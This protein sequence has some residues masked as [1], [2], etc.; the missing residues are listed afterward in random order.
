MCCRRQDTLGA[1]LV[2]D[3]RVISNSTRESV[4]G[5]GTLLTSSS[6]RFFFSLSLSLPLDFFLLLVRSL[7]VQL[8][9]DDSRF[10][11]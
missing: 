2:Q 8:D 9:E 5:L 3:T 1:F 4:P 11:P 7:V 6:R 10:S